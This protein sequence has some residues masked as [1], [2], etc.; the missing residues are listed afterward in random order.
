MAKRVSNTAVG[1]F[2][3][4]AI[5]IILAAVTVFGSGQFFGKKYTFVCFFPSDLNG[6]KV[7]APVKMRGV[8][9]GSVT[10]IKLRLP[11]QPPLLETKNHKTALPV[12]FEIDEEQLKAL[13]ARDDLGSRATINRF[14]QLGLRAR[15]NM[16]SLLTG[17]LCV[18]LDF[19]PEAPLVLVL[20]SDTKYLE[21]PAI[22]TEIEQLQEAATSALAKLDKIDFKALIDA[23]TGAAEAAQSF[24]GSPDLKR[25]VGQ[26]NRTIASFRHTSEAI[27]KA[28][29]DLNRS[30]DPLIA[31]LRQ[32]SNQARATLAATRTTLTE[33]D[34]VVNPNSPMGYQIVQTLKDLDEASRS[35]TALSDMLQTDP[36]AIIWGKRQ[37]K[38]QK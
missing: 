13:G 17:L 14:V 30:L 33:I 4:A 36:N 11:E 31:S 37:A 27:G 26:L 15:L 21:V 1:G 3:V 34:G 22:P 29:A 12:F 24:I 6:L 10:N 9:I 19:H 28:T 35:I 16:E 2:V 5:A 38:T 7:G 8:Q 20:P 18:D 23:L 32:T 25:A